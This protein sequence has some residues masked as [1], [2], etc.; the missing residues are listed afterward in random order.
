MGIWICGGILAYLLATLGLTYLVHQ[1]PRRPVCDPPDW[2]TVIDTR[3][4]ALGG[5]FLEVWRVEPDEASRGI[6]VLAHGWGRNRDRMVG[7]AR[8][9]GRWGYTTVI[10][11]ARDHGGS[12]PRR[13]M[14]AHRF[15]EDIE[16]V[17]AWVGQPVILYGHSAGSAGA[18]VAAVRRPDLVRLL[19]L[20]GAYAETKAALRHL[21]LAFNRA[22]G[23]IFGPAIVFWMDKVFYRQTLEQLSPAAIA[24]RIQVPVQMIHGQRDA[25]FPLELPKKLLGRFPAGQA[26]LWVA[27]GASHSECP[28]HPLYPQVVKSFLD[29]YD[30]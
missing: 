6:V 8:M 7:R 10:H 11:S 29:T 5:G 30:K 16:S 18:M 14:N 22:F 2:G 27:P 1:Q 20:E 17:L 3:I 19:F 28:L 23:T 25:T 21:Y 12:S 13:W 24:P 15:G 26:H 4:P 9:F